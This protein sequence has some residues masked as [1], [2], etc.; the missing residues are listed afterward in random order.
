MSKQL[1]SPFPL[2]L[3]FLHFITISAQSPAQAP[4]QAPTPPIFPPPAPPA[5]PLL[6]P[7]ALAPTTNSPNIYTILKK[8]SQ[9]STFLQLLKITQVGDQIN[10]QL[11]KNQRLT[12][13]A[14]PDNA[15]GNLKSGTLN[16]LTDQQQSELMQFHVLTSFFSGSQFQ[17]VSNPLPTEAGSGGRFPLNVTTSGNSVNITTGIVN[18]TVTHTLYSDNQLAVYQVDKVLLTYDIFGPPTPAAAPAPLKPLKPKKKAP[19][20]D[21]DADAPSESES[22]QESAPVLPS[23]AIGLVYPAL[24]AICFVVSITAVFSLGSKVNKFRAM[25]CMRRP[26]G[27]LASGGKSS[28]LLPTRTQR[29][30]SAWPMMK[31]C[32]LNNA[33]H[34]FMS[35]KICLESGDP[36]VEGFEGSHL[37]FVAAGSDPF[38]VI[39]NTVKTVERHLQTFC[40]SQGAAVHNFVIQLALLMVASESIKIYN[41]ISDGTFN[42]VDKLMTSWAVVCDVWYQEP[43]NLKLGQT[44]IEF[45]ES[46]LEPIHIQLSA[47]MCSLY[48]PVPEFQK[49]QIRSFLKSTKFDGFPFWWYQTS[50]MVNL[51]PPALLLPREEFFGNSYG[52]CTWNSFLVEQKSQQTQFFNILDAF[53]LLN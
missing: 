8:A 33:L 30:G 28:V 49:R 14:P 32:S 53:L 29:T 20:S 44:P 36:A 35:F 25:A 16:K 17:T 42:L 13:F 37:V 39:T 48:D 38:D 45:A 3:I 12:V 9:F 43:Q 24:N 50:L 4:A 11:S 19:S 46:S 23:G 21:A 2:L 18:A 7:L 40:Q 1:L 41:A 51:P 26:I 10:I 27:H 47:K 52:L 6:A 34:F 31:H 15:F 22:S 5:A